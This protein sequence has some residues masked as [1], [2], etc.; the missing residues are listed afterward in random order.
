MKIEDNIPNK[1]LLA[2]CKKNSEKIAYFSNIE[3]GRN[4]GDLLSSNTRRGYVFNPHI[5]IQF[6][7]DEFEII[8]ETLEYLDEKYNLR[9]CHTA[10]SEDKEIY[11]GYIVKDYIEENYD[12]DYERNKKVLARRRQLYIPSKKRKTELTSTPQFNPKSNY[13][14]KYIYSYLRKHLYDKWKLLQGKQQYHYV[15]EQMDK[16]NIRVV[17]ITDTLSPKY[18]IVKNSAIFIDIEKMR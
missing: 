4:K 17:E 10:I 3:F 9:N 11:Y 18:K 5:H 2:W 7:Y 8:E 15:V 14:I 12:E 1:R 16:K 13:A 6:F